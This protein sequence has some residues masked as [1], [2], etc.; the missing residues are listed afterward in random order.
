[1]KNDNKILDFTI[2]LYSNRLKIVKEVVCKPTE[3]EKVIDELTH[4]PASPEGETV[5]MVTTSKS[6]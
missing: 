1:M 4:K 2:T 6:K 5:T 3:V